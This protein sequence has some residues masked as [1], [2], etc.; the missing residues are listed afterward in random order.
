[1][2]VH[3][4]A[5]LIIPA[6]AGIQARLRLNSHYILARIPAAGSAHV[7]CAARG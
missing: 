2:D 6:K 5:R 4:N 3:Q 1:M 7:P